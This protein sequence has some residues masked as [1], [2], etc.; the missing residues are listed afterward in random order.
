M[1]GRD[2]EDVSQPD[3]SQSIPIVHVVISRCC[4][5]LEVIVFKLC[6]LFGCREHLGLL[7]NLVRPGQWENR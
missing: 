7:V 2:G 4:L 5:L 1:S 3:L 6:C